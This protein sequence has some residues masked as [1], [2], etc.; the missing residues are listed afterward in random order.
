M[1]HTGDD[2]QVLQRDSPVGYAHSGFHLPEPGLPL[3]VAVKAGA[4]LFQIGAIEHAIP[5]LEVAVDGRA[6]EELGKAFAPQ[7][8]ACLGAEVAG[9]DL[10]VQKARQQGLAVKPRGFQFGGEAPAGAPQQVGMAADGAIIGQQTTVP[11]FQPLVAQFAAG[12]EFVENQQRPVLILA[13]D[14]AVADAEGALHHGGLQQVREARSPQGDFQVAMKY[15]LKT[16]A[17]EE[18]DDGS[19]AQASGL[20]VAL[21]PPALA[22]AYPEGAFEGALIGLDVQLGKAQAVCRE[23]AMGRD[24]VE[25]QLGMEG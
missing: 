10:V 23:L 4:G 16:A 20:Q 8:D 12:A 7:L 3:A 17:L 14:D 13:G 1:Q 5:Q 22:P 9:D 18:V 19:H 11:G 24:F 6:H 2:L 15:P 21:D 25:A